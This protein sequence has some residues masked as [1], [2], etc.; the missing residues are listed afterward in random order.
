MVSAAF[1][2]KLQNNHV[3]TWQQRLLDMESLFKHEY[4]CIKW[5]VY[6]V[7]AGAP[8]RLFFSAKRDKGYHIIPF[9]TSFFSNQTYMLVEN[10]IGQ[11]KNLDHENYIFCGYFENLRLVY[12]QNKRLQW[13]AFIWDLAFSI[14]WKFSEIKDIRKISFAYNI[15]YC[16]SF[17]RCRSNSL[18]H[19]YNILGSAT[20]RQK[21]IFIN[22]KYSDALNWCL[23]KSSLS[24]CSVD[25]RMTF[26]G[27]WY[28]SSFMF[29]CR[30]HLHNCSRCDQRT[31]FFFS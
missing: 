30:N 22:W 6:A 8:R 27:N 17:T 4:G 12:F 24:S 3:H 11:I 13:K 20:W 15:T 1:D 29:A 9:D 16:S 28:V 18:V 2:L 23:Q 10:E 19:I 21:I 5:S 25:W 26:I 7:A 14:S 31:V